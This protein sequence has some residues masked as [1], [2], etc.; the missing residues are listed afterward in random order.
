MDVAKVTFIASVTAN[1]GA[2]AYLIM[3]PSAKRRT[4]RVNFFSSDA[5]LFLLI[6]P[7]ASVE[8]GTGYILQTGDDVHFTTDEPVYAAPWSNVDVSGAKC[9]VS[10]I[11]TES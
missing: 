8:T 6:G 9:I 10:A 3:Y 7:Q 5:T 4:V 11:R 2:T 1:Q